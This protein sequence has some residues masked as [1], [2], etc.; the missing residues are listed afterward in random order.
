MDTVFIVQ[1]YGNKDPM[2]SLNDV[3]TLELYAD[4]ADEAIERAK[5][6][7]E[8]EF[9]RISKVIEING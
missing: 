6:L 9:Y 4:T 1:G 2:G 7:V 5:K 3:C 8:K